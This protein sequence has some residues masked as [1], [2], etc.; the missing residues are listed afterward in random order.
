MQV[1][2]VV[3]KDGRSLDSTL[4]VVG[5]GA[6]P[7]LAPFKGLLE[8]EKGGFKVCTGTLFL[9]ASLHLKTKLLTCWYVLNVGPGQI[10]V[11]AKSSGIAINWK[12][13]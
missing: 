9:C 13:H 1:S 7:L 10:C 4:V 3:L 8:E 5:V 12:F 2:K 6:K 11:V